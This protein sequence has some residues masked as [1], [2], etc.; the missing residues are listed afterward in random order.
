MNSKNKI[1]LC[2]AMG[3]YGDSLCVIFAD[4]S[5]QI[6][7]KKQELAGKGTHGGGPPSSACRIANFPVKI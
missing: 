2:N 4:R 7:N 5:K 1:V 6:T 3:G